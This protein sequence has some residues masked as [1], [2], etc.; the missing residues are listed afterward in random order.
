MMR[1]TETAHPFVSLLTLPPLRLSF[2]CLTMTMVFLSNSDLHFSGGFLG[3]M[4]RF[5][6][7]FA[8]FYFFHGGVFLLLLFLER[9]ELLEEYAE[10]V[11]LGL[12]L[13]RLP[14]E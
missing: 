9:C 8:I 2:L 10:E 4:S 7:F 5:G 13:Y 14:L 3:L 6:G 12:P 11:D 1:S